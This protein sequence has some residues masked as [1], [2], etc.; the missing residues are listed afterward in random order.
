MRLFYWILL[1]VSAALAACTPD[2]TC[3]RGDD[4]VAPA[5][6]TLTRLGTLQVDGAPVEDIEHCEMVTERIGFLTA[7]LGDSLIALRTEDG[8]E[9]WERLLIDRS[10]RLGE[11]AFHSIDTG[12]LLAWAGDG[13]Q[14]LITTNGGR[15]WREQ[16]L[17]LDTVFRRSLR[18]HPNGTLYALTGSYD[19]NVGL[20]RSQDGG[21][22]WSTIYTSHC[23]YI[24]G[25]HV[26]D[27]RLYFTTGDAVVVTDLDG[28]VVKSTAIVAFR[29]F[30]TVQNCNFWTHEKKQIHRS[31]DHQGA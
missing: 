1:L 6:F 18:V 30:K 5:G 11:F 17:G 8:G 31:A 14:V 20:A 21:A 19:R 10:F 26:L 27:D 4:P 23:P 7:S 3:P 16:T 25:L 29:N 2:A 28:A 15:T 24:D 9:R 22:S 12:Y 13:T